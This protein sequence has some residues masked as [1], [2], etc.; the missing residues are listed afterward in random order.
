MLIEQFEQ[1]LK[2]SLFNVAQSNMSDNNHLDWSAKN[3]INNKLTR[4]VID[5]LNLLL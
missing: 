2:R 1:I 3:D 4:E 5:R